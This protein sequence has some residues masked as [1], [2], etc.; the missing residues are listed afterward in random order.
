MVL[1]LEPVFSCEL[2]SM[3]ICFLMS[4]VVIDSESRFLGAYSVGLLGG[5]NLSVFLRA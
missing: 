2:S 4:I 5:L 3:V 1:I